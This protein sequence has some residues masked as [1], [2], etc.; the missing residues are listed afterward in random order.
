MFELH[1]ED[2]RT[3]EVSWSKTVHPAR[4][5]KVGHTNY[6][7]PK[8][9]S[10]FSTPSVKQLVRRQLRNAATDWFRFHRVL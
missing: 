6:I 4:R 7:L 5:T 3:A 9:T 2:R 1:N 10:R 8:A